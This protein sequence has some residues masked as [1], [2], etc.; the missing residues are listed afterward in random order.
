M[1]FA[2]DTDYFPSD[3]QWMINFRGEG[4]DILPADLRAAAIEVATN[5][6][7]VRLVRPYP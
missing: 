6:A 2:T 7:R 1:P 4:L 3:K 5:P